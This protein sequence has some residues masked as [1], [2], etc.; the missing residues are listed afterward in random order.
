MY[1]RL[2]GVGRGVSDVRGRG[3]PFKKR[4]GRAVSLKGGGEVRPGGGGQAMLMAGA[5]PRGGRGG[6]SRGARAPRPALS[7]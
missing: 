1:S 7:L 6:A 2:R 5:V 4:P 3:G